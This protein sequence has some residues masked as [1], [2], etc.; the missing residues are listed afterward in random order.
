MI[1]T[2]IRTTALACVLLTST[3]IIAPALAQQQSSSPLP[4][5][6]TV[7]SNDVN[8]QTGLV[9]IPRRAYRSARATVVSLIR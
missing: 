2:S 6:S 4:L 5:R 8:L 9:S 1:P 7:E 3:A